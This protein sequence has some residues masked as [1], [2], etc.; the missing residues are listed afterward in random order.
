MNRT[1]LAT[2]I[3]M[4]AASA[5]FAT[6]ARVEAMGK[7]ATYF[8]DDANIWLN[9]A[10]ANLYPNY[11]L[12]EL[13]VMHD[14][15]DTSASNNPWG[16]MQRYNSDPSG[17]WFGAIF[18]KSL[19]KDE[20]QTG[21]YPQVLIGGAFNRDDEWLSYMPSNV[22]IRKVNSLNPSQVDVQTFNVSDYAVKWDGILGFASDSGNL[23]GL[24]TYF[25]YLDS[26]NG[27]FSAQSVVNTY[28][29]GA[30]LPFGSSMSLELNGTIGFLSTTISNGTGSQSGSAIEYKTDLSP[31]IGGDARMF[32]DASPWPLV[33]VP[34]ASFRLINAPSRTLSKF[35]VGS[36]A[37]VS[38]DRGFFWMGVD[39]FNTSDEIFAAGMDTVSESAK[40]VNIDEN[41]LR[42][43]FGI[44]RNIWTDWFVIRV[45]GQKIIKQV[46]RTGVGGT[47]SVL[48]TNPESNNYDEDLVS[49]G[50]GV[51]IEDK[52]KVD[53][54]MEKDILFTGGS[55][56]G[57]EPDHVLSRI[58]ASYSF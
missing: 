57:R 3:S 1:V 37:N 29:L 13:G 15:K 12:G 14:G 25:A 53:A 48:T 45:G 47:Y 26:T 17:T 39:Y 42:V 31:S 56:L 52:F 41:G 58:S 10:N 6:S 19:G 7:H 11:L 33:V 32:I 36:G 5:A 40:A 43:S 28:T 9:P 44:E 46:D 34:A 8:Q 54:V 30:N 23:F 50:F 27:K 20:T 49:F 55:L 16:A 2:A 4:A 35:R 24:K 18:A 22:M 51:N 38:L 21:R